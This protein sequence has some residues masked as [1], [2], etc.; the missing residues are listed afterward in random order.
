MM[1]IGTR[2]FC[3]SSLGL[4]TLLLSMWNNEDGCTMIKVFREVSQAYRDTD[5][6]AIYDHVGCASDFVSNHELCVKLN[7]KYTHILA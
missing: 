6:I 1:Q 7:P 4:V 2:L 3:S 5:T